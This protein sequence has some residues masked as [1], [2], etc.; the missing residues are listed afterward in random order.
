M[1]EWSNAFAWKANKGE[2]P[3]GVR[4]PLCPPNTEYLMIRFYNICTE[5]WVP[6]EGKMMKITGSHQVAAASAEEARVAF[7]RVSNKEKITDVLL[8]VV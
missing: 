1:A 3:S 2:S 6:I 4:I 5:E 8:E 7:R